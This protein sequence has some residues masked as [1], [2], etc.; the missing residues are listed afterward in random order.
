M[1]QTHAH[2]VRAVAAFLM[3][4]MVCGCAAMTAFHKGEQAEKRQDWD[5]AVIEY[6]KALA[7]SPGNTHFSV[8]LAR[9]RLRASAVHF[10]RGKFYV[11]AGA[12]ELATAEFEQTIFLDSSNQYAG[13]ELLKVRETIRKKQMSPSE[14]ERAKAAAKKR[15]LAPPKLSP[16]SNLPI[17]LKFKDQP[18]GKIYDALSKASGINFLYD[19]RVDQ[20]QTQTV[21]I[22][23][24]SLEKAMGILM[25]Q[26]KHFYKIIDENTLLI[27]PDNRQK[28]QE[29]EDRVIRTFYLSNGDTKQV[30][31]VLR[32]L[33]DARKVA[34]NP[35]LNSLTI[36]DSPDVVAVAE[37]IIEANDK[38]K[39]E[40]VIDVELLELNRTKLQELGMDLTSKSLSLAFL[41]GAATIPLNNLDL[42]KQQS[43]WSIGPIPGIAIYFAKAFTDSKVLAKP[44]VRVTDGEKAEIHIG[45]RVPIPSTTFNTSNT[46]GGSIVPVTSFTYQNIGI[47]ITLEPRVHHNREITMKLNVS[48]SNIAGNIQGSGGVSQPIIGQRQIQSVI[49]LKDG[50]TNLMAGLVR[51]EDTHDLA[52][53]PGLADIP[54][55]NRIFSRNVDKTQRTDIVLTITPHIIR[56]PDITEADMESIWVGTEEQTK[57][58]IAA[59]A[60]FGETPFGEGEE[61]GTESETGA[62]GAA[63]V[64][65]APAAGAEAPKIERQQQPGKTPAGAPSEAAPNPVQPAPE[66]VE[67]D[68]DFVD[69]EEGDDEELPDEAGG[70]QP[71]GAEQNRKAAPPAEDAAKNPPSTLVQ[72]VLAS[73]KTAYAV[74]EPVPVEVRVL[75]GQNVGSI[76]FHLRYNPAVL[77][78]QGPGMEG[79]YL[80]RDGTATVF[81]AT[82]VVGGGEIVVGASRVGSPTG[83]TGEGTLATFTFVA[84]GAGAANF[85]FTG[86]SVKDPNANNLPA[87]FTLSP[88]TVQGK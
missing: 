77:D 19:E 75:G 17:V 53:I 48:I 71:P 18:I 57:L 13:I 31:T 43:N 41:G 15:S 25:L 68:T 4:A 2:L 44:Q 82:P 88:V 40:L 67:E 52:G 76:P 7:T 51:D 33:L 74:G 12:L 28:R 35:E 54:L 85:S 20:K 79:D 24:V 38:A 42:L 87:S 70:G 62:P 69:E 61:D 59:R 58:R 66:E 47:E 60:P 50:E 81:V 8:A 22:A 56:V 84:K 32:Q 34:E 3:F 72:V 78:F 86:A 55:L 21:D 30:N 5:R 73:P 1:R 36:K 29:Y 9:A 49:R 39:A 23:G 63:D 65:T 83:A 16:K 46:V 37:K 10:D 26:N 6:V 64:A 45:D 27:A 80:N 11:K 14:I